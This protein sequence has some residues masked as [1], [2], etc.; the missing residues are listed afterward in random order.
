MKDILREEWPE[1]EDD[2]KMISTEMKTSNFS[3]RSYY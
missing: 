3:K 2:R 1:D